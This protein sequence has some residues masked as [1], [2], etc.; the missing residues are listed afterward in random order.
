[1]IA[2]DTAGFAS[3]ILRL[4]SDAELWNQISR[5]SIATLEPFTSAAISSTLLQM[6]DTVL[7][8]NWVDVA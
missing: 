2:D 6:L 7:E 1:M 8:V 5:N 4:Y 3:A